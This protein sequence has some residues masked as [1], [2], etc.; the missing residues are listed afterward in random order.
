MKVDSYSIVTLPQTGIS[1]LIT[2]WPEF[3]INLRP[4]AK[5]YNYEENQ[6][7]E[8]SLLEIYLRKLEWHCEVNIEH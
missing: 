1:N 4:W 2:K 7:K 6:M 5:Q 3:R 8:V